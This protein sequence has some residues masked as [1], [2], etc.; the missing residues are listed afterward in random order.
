MSPPPPTQTLAGGAVTINHVRLHPYSSRLPTDQPA[1]AMVC[2][3]N[4]PSVKNAVDRSTATTLHDAFTAFAH[5]PSL[6][7]AIL[8]GAGGTFCAGADLKAIL[9]SASSSDAGN[10]L[11]PNLDAPAPMGI[12]RLAMNK[13]VIAAVEG[14]AVAGGLEL[15]LWADL[16]VAC[17]KS[18]FGVLCRLRGVPLIDGGTVR[19]PALIGGSRAAELSL[20]GRLVGAREAEA[21][22]L[23]N[24]VVPKGEGKEG[25]SNVMVKALE[26]A[27]GMAA[28]PQTC[29]LNDR[30][31][32]LNAMYPTV[33]G[34]EKA[35][36]DGAE[37][38]VDL[39]L[40]GGLRTAMQREFELGLN[41]LEK[42]FEEGAVGAFVNR[43]GEQRDADRKAR[44]KL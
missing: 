3:I 10:L 42:L 27:A 17:E 16:R 9:S 26:V 44:S 23:V 40:K 30:T 35:G 8:T 43:T 12:T 22:G 20:T 25:W 36:R 24:Y 18:H 15:A 14:F 33:E 4:R 29:M 31:S 7:V 41:S 32:M 37:G 2:T 13:P 5:D 28:N 1:L 19:L 11:D 6:Q 34:P 39:R 38:V 21:M